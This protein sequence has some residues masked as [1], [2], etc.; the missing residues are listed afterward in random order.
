MPET[1]RKQKKGKRAQL[2]S[3]LHP[4]PWLPAAPGSGAPL[5]AQAGAHSELR[6]SIGSHH[7]QSP[8]RSATAQVGEGWRGLRVCWI[9]KRRG[10]SHCGVG[11]KGFQRCPCAPLPQPLRNT[12]PPFPHQPG[13]SR[14]GPRSQ[15]TAPSP[16]AA[17][18]TAC[19]PLGC[20]DQ[21]LPRP[22]S[23]CTLPTMQL[24][25]LP[26]PIRALAS[27][28]MRRQRTA[29]L[30]SA[31]ALLVAPTS[32]PKRSGS[33][34]ATAAGFWARCR[35][36]KKGWGRCPGCAPPPLPVPQS[37]RPA[38]ARPATPPSPLPRCSISASR[39]RCI[40]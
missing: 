18:D 34:A 7:T 4:V 23:R 1:K 6:T 5:R 22:S 33:P 26:R 30:S 25:W 20:A 11:T 17:P 16:P 19:C 10:A 24:P 21:P 36:P 38:H 14:C 35:V 32:T 13:P 28:E 40:L 12:P 39:G 8:K 3:P 27:P 31:G 15:H 9:R 2:P 29:P 37:V